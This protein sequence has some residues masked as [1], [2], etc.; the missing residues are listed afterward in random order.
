M[1][2]GDDMSVYFLDDMTGKEMNVPRFHTMFKR[3]RKRK[4]Y[5]FF[6]TSQLYFE[7][8]EKH[9]DLLGR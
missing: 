4:I 7:L 9:Y 5:I 6:G 3:K 2:Y 1:E 8:A